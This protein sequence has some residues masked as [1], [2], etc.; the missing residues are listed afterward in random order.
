[1]DLVFLS[2]LLT[3]ERE[4]ESVAAS[5]VLA[6]S[7]VTGDCHGSRNGKMKEIADDQGKQVQQLA[8]LERVMKKQERETRAERL[9]EA[10]LEVDSFIPK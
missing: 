1:M 8:A 7:L 5:A 2:G 3:A 6:M 9:V 4:R 10:L